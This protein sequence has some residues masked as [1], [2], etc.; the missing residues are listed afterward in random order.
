MPTVKPSGD[1]SVGISLSLK[2]STLE[3]IRRIALANDRSLSWIVDHAVT[4]WI[5][6]NSKPEG[7][8]NN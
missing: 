6:R 7:L 2:K 1:P 3:R 5:N 4:D 8:T